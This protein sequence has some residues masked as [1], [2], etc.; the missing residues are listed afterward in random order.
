MMKN[1]IKE[2]PDF[3]LEELNDNHSE[4]LL[5]YYK[6]NKDHLERWEPIRVKKFYTIDFLNIRKKENKTKSNK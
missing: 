3:I 6:K 4:L 1:S 5:N 2:A